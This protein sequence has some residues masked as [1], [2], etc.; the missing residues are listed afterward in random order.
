[1]KRADPCA[2]SRVRKR[3]A[4]GSISPATALTWWTGSLSANYGEMYVREAEGLSGGRPF[5]VVDLPDRHDAPERD[6]FDRYALAVNG[7]V[8][9]SFTKFGSCPLLIL[10]GGDIVTY[11][12][13]GAG[14]KE[15]FQTLAGIRTVERAVHLYWYLD[16]AMAKCTD[17]RSQTVF[18]FSGIV[19]TISPSKQQHVLWDRFS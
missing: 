18:P 7:A 11:I 19:C 15:L 3:A 16:P 10:S 6:L 17:P 1:M 12:P 5:I 13:P 9:G 8:Q 4:T 2:F 14:E